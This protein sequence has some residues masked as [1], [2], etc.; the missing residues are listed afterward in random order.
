MRVRML[1]AVAAV[2]A[3]SLSAT[4]Y[5]G[6]QTP[7]GVRATSAASASGSPKQAPQR[8][9]LA[10][11]DSL[12]TGFQPTA[13]G[14]A[15][16]T[17]QGYVN[18]LYAYEQ[19]YVP[20]LTLVQMGCPGD[21]TTSLLTGK[22]NAALSKAFKCDR[23]GGSQL[24]AAVAFLKAHRSRGEVPLVTIDIGANDIDGCASAANVGT[25]ITAGL[26]TI[27]T[28]LPKILSALRKAAPAGTRF[29]TMNLYDP[30]LSNYLLPTTD[31]LQALGLGSVP[32][33]QQVN[34]TLATDA[35]AANFKL[36]DVAD[37]FDSYNTTTMVTWNGV[38]VPQ[39]VA[40]LCAWTWNCSPP[41]VGP[42]IHA[43]ALGYA[44]IA[45]AFEKIIGKL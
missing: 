24:A 42:N 7:H 5:A 11:G 23:Q 12:S 1:L 34:T 41:P 25:C 39:D 4:G 40:L 30:V 36:A 44:V 28:N 19:K 35:S 21:T 43:N 13:N 18:D 38:Q 45:Q 22:G 32:L 15:A 2:A 29:A 16:N 8:Y 27:N 14:G 9:Y 10:L 6:A 37:A 17:T 20:G 31:P 3:G 26:T 33:L